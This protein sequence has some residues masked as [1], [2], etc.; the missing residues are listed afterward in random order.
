MTKK[1]ELK[2]ELK[3]VD[4]FGIIRLLKK[5]GLDNISKSMSSDNINELLAEGGSESQIGM[6][7]ILDIAQVIIDRISDCEAELYSF[8]AQVSNLSVKEVKDLGMDEFVGMIIDLVQ[9]D[10]F[11]RAFTKVVSLFK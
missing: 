1:Y 11:K 5:I 2:E 10:D 6:A 3:A 9:R 7:V 4:L 8:L